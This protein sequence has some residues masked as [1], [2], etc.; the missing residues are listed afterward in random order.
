MRRAA[1]IL[2]A[3]CTTAAALTALTAAPARAGDD[4]TGLGHCTGSAPLVCH[5]DVA[6]GTYRVSVLL[7]GDA[8]AGSTGVTAETRRTVLAE[9]PSAPGGTVRRSFTVDVRDPEGEPTG[10]T[11]SPGL[12]LTFGGTAPQ[13]DALRVTPVRT[14]R[15]LLAGDSAVCDQPGAFYS[16]WGQQLP[17]HLTG[18]L[19]VANHADSGEGSQSFLDNPDSRSA[20][21]PTPPRAGPPSTPPWSWLNSAPRGSSQGELSADERQMAGE[22]GSSPAIRPAGVRG[23]T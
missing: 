21:T 16:G 10:A 22:L 9:T 14:P 19:T 17:R 15:I 5:L 7:G 6:P 1:T 11:G 2:L 18:R 20:P 12:D 13:L 23:G 3:A 8:E 4:P